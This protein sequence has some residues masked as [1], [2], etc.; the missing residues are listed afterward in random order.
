MVIS[1][2]SICRLE[3]HYLEVSFKFS[4]H[5]LQLKSQVAHANDVYFVYGLVSQLNQT[6]SS[7]AL[8]SAM[9]DYWVS[10]ATSLDPNDGLGVPRM[11]LH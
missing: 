6:A 3:S 8:S 5:D 11:C 10:F 4:S 1:L 2:N 9:I 7:I